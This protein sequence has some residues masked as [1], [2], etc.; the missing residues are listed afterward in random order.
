MRSSVSTPPTASTSA[1][2][3]A[4]GSSSSSTFSMLSE[5]CSHALS[6]YK[7]SLTTKV[8]MID[9][10]MVFSIAN[11]IIQVLSAYWNISLSLLP[12]FSLI[13]RWYSAFTFYLLVHFPSTPSLP[14]FFV[15]S[16]RL[17]LLVS[18]CW[19]KKRKITCLCFLFHIIYLHCICSL[20]TTP[21]YFGRLQRHLHWARF[22]RLCTLLSGSL[23]RSVQFSGVKVAYEVC[24]DIMK[25]AAR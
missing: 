2:A 15:I 1:F 9:A 6:A 5:V 7:T 19:L 16:A 13:S 22:W 14:E 10:F 4:S 17:S 21:V 23:L 8:M 18:N 12:T 25:N 24:C 11:I 3:F 20:A